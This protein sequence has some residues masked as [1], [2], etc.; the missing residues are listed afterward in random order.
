MENSG[1]NAKRAVERPIASG[2]EAK[3]ESRSKIEKFS[4]TQLGSLR[5]AL[6]DSGI[7]SWQ[8]AEVL[9]N[10]LTGRG[11]GVNP[12]RARDAIAHLEGTDRAL[13]CMQEEL[14]R[15]AFVM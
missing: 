7:D 6:M 13:A 8:A 12:Q 3:A 10:F 9:S 15:V 4:A 5:M 14:E 1:S 2:I 11:Y